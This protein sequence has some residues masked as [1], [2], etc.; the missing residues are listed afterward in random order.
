MEPISTPNPYLSFTSD[1][2]FKVT[3]GN[4]NQT[5]F[6]RQAIQAIIGS[7]TP[8]LS[9]SFDKT[10]FEGVTRD[11]RSGIYDLACHDE[12]GNFFIVEMQLGPFRD[13]LQ[14]L[15]FYSFQ[16][17]NTIV[18]KGDFD[19]TN[20]S[21][22]YCIGILGSG[23]TELTG[24]HHIGAIRTAAGQIMDEQMK[25]VLVE[26]KKFDK[27]PEYCT[28]DLDKLLYTMKVISENEV[29]PLE[30]PQFWTE[31]WL[32]IALHELDT[33]AM[34]AEDRMAYEI[35]LSNN[36][37]AIRQE[38][39]K[40]EAADKKG[41]K[42]GVIKTKKE[43][44]LRMIKMGMSDEAIAESIAETPEFVRALRV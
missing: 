37:Y 28:T 2:G 9:V 43:T 21:K 24:Y 10:T 33:R 26:L 35:T 1:Y 42:K 19:Y 4:E 13:V 11:S 36:A 17:F 5:L 22:I 18:K 30:Y 6:L 40:I 31:E 14:R 27:K 3:F 38:K 23:Q 34:T 41:I 20:L 8:I 39:N 25:F 44:A 32:K 7:D 15:K 29:L 16:K 12:D